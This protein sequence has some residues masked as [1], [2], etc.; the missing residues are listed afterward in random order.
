MRILLSAIIAAVFCLC[1][2]AQTQNDP[3]RVVLRD[4]TDVTKILDG[5]GTKNKVRIVCDRSI[6]TKMKEPD[7]NLTLEQSLDYV[8]S[9]VGNA[10][11]RRVYVKKAAQVPN[12]DAL[13][14]QVRAII[15]IES[16]GII[17][18]DAQN[19]S[20][21]F[22]KTNDP[23]LAK[24]DF[25]DAPI[26]VVTTI[27]P[28]NMPI[29]T[30]ANG[31]L[32]SSDISNIISQTMQVFTKMSSQ[33]QQSF[34]QQVATAWRNTFNSLPPEQQSQYR[35]GG[36]RNHTTEPNAGQQP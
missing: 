11:W 32:T 15:S 34:M 21:V 4:L 17:V 25:E 13:C 16:S 18:Q 14:S 6:K 9:Y 2:I 20:S 10:A 24:L 28:N 36:R 22:S 12:A 30:G 1:A 29:G 35:G 27:K 3:N 31:E 19:N 5:L 8:V 23:K 26:Y 7:S 33:E